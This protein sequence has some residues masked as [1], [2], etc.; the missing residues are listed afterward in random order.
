MSVPCGSK[1]GSQSASTRVPTR[2]NAGPQAGDESGQKRIEGIGSYQEAIDSEEK[3]AQRGERDEN[4][5]KFHLSGCFLLV[6][7][8]KTIAQFLHFHHEFSIDAY[9]AVVISHVQK[10]GIVGCPESIPCILFSRRFP[11]RGISGECV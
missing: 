8:S 6:L 9:K 5:Q 7:S 4:V 1:L 2:K 10:L 11:W 3:G